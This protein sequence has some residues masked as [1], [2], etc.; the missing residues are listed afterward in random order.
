MHAYCIEEV[1]YDVGLIVSNRRDNR[2]QLALHEVGCTGPSTPKAHTQSTH[3]KHTPKAHT[4]KAHIKH[5]SAHTKHTPSKPEAHTRE[6]HKQTPNTSQAQTIKRN[7]VTPRSITRFLVMTRLGVKGF[8]RG[9]NHYTKTERPHS[10]PHKTPWDLARH[11]RPHK[12]RSD[13]TQDS[14]QNNTKHPK[15]HRDPKRPLAG[16]AA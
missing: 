12:T 5:T 2:N 14:I 8:L 1:V 11:A 10:K 9:T 15:T 13:T 16:A 7:A 6:H 3:P 4:P